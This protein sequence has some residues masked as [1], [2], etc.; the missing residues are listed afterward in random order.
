MV[1]VCCCPPSRSH[2]RPCKLQPTRLSLC[3]VRTVPDFLRA[4]HTRLG[5]WARARVLYHHLALGLALRARAAAV[6]VGPLHAELAAAVVREHAVLVLA[7]AGVGTLVAHV[8]PALVVVL[9]VE[10]PIGV[11]AVRRLLVQP[12]V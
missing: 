6:L 12:V 2:Q 9:R 8:V 11:V 1:C 3:L 10:E 5:L 7:A 4:V